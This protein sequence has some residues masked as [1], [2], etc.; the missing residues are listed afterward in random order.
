MAFEDVSVPEDQIGGPGEF[1]QFKDVSQTLEAVFASQ[2]KSTSK[3][4]KEG[5]HRY[6]FVGSKDPATGKPRVLILDPAPTHLEMSLNRA[7][8]AGKLKVGAKVQIKHTK[9]LPPKD[10]TQSGMKLFSV[11]VDLSSATPTMLEAIK[12]ALAGVPAPAA[13]APPPPPPPPAPAN[14]DPF[15]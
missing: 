8:E 4:A 2:S 3:Y 9:V 5:D 1:Y 12:K 13:A 14:D 15:A 6:V 10:P 11:A 7:L